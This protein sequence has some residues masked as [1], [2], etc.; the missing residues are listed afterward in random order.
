[1]NLVLHIDIVSF[2][3]RN[4]CTRK[5]IFDAIKAALDN[6]DVPLSRVCTA[7]RDGANAVSS[8]KEGKTHFASSSTVSR[9]STTWC[10]GQGKSGAPTWRPSYAAAD[11][12]TAHATA[13][14][15]A[16][17]VAVAAAAAAAGLRPENCCAALELARI[18][19]GS[20]RV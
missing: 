8:V 10:G 16:N 1:M 18:A 6:F 15:A 2:N 19:A 3:V 13:A 17:A 4:K 14:S 9:I 7:T 11:H 20:T 5:V 12:A